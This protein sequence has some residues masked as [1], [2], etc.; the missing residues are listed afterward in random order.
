MRR[1]ALFGMLCLALVG[2]DQ[3]ESRESKKILRLNIAGEPISLDPRL[4]GERRSQVVTNML[5]EGLTRMTAEG[6]AELAMAERVEISSDKRTYT[7]HLRDAHWSTGQ[8][9]TAYD[10]E[11][12]WKRNLSPNFDSLHSYLLFNIRNAQKVRLG[13]LPS[14]ELGVTVVDPRTLVVELE[15]PAP[16]FLDLLA[17]P[18]LAPVP[19]F[20]DRES[21]SWS[22][23]VDTFVCNGPF[24]LVEWKHEDEIRVVKNPSYWDGDNVQIDG[25]TLSIIED[26]H[27]VLSLFEQGAL[28]WVGEPLSE[29][30]LDSIEA[31]SRSG[32]LETTPVNATYEYYF[33]TELPLF[34]SQKVRQP[35]RARR[36]QRG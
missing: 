24:Q 32:K 16:Y 33:N 4:G 3:Q 1:L 25:I 27:S 26:S 14:S 12:S 30:P 7:F 31:L 19:V 23:S 29:L 22:R 15:S 21:N 28:D 8:P 13:E 18:I 9:V 20:L 2:C 35:S 10:F 5:F 36:A 11:Q 6:P 17:L 34:S